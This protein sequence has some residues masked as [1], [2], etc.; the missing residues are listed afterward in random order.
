MVTKSSARTL[1]MVQLAILEA[2]LL[3]MAFTPLGYLQTASGIS[4]SFLALPVA[5]GAV[6]LGAKAGL[7][8]G[9]TFGLTSFIQCFTGDAFGASL[10]QIQPFFTAIVC[11]LPRCLVGVVPALLFH[12][13]QK[14]DKLDFVSYTLSCLAASLTNT[15]GFLGFLILF[16]EGTDAMTAMGFSAGFLYILKIIGSLNGLLEAAIVT[17]LGTA[18]CKAL[19][20]FVRKQAPSAKES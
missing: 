7:I 3:I 8:L 13:L 15:I 11:I 10:V 9:F 2:I 5:V 19:S 6:I 16:F 17:V 4:I 14:I 1:F 12:G 18:I 20:V